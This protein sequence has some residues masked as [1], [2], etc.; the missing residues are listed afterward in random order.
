L[1]KFHWLIWQAKQEKFETL[2]ESI[3]EEIGEL[4]LSINIV[5][6]EQELIRQAQ[7]NHYWATINE[8]KFDELI[9]KLSPL[10]KFREA[11]I[12]LAP[13]KFNL[14]DIVAEKEF[15]EFGPQHE[16]LSV[17]KYRE[18]VEKKINELVSSSPIL[19]KLKQGQEI[20][21]KKRSNWPKNCT[22][23]IRTLPLICFARFTTTAKRHWC[24]SSNIF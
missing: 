5:A 12:P 8:E 24:N 13:A 17:A 9:Q 21:T 22:T 3:I 16:A 6:R 14:K 10:M 18:L 11:V 15:V 20:T 4:P 7:S 23:N 1:W 19:Q 2:K